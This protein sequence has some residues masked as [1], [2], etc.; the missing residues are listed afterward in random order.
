MLRRGYAAA[1]LALVVS[2]AGCAGA[3]SKDPPSSLTYAEFREGV[4]RPGSRLMYVFFLYYGEYGRFPEDLH[5]LAAFAEKKNE[6]VEWQ[7]FSRFAISGEPQVSTVRVDVTSPSSLSES[8]EVTISWRLVI[9]EGRGG[10]N[11]LKVDLSPETSFCLRQPGSLERTG[12]QRLME[13]LNLAS[14]VEKSRVCYGP[15][16][17][18]LGLRDSEIRNLRDLLQDL[19]AKRATE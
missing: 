1:G 8:G 2:I 18:S 14:S 3:R 7:R 4:D 5:S 13:T 16:T 12:F 10:P 11:D 6:A 15:S 19:G 9:R 17:S